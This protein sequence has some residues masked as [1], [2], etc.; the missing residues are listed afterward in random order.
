MSDEGKTKSVLQAAEKARAL[1]LARLRTSLDA[2]LEKNFVILAVDALIAEAAEGDPQAELWEKLHAAAA[3]DAVEDAV[4][5]AYLRSIDGPR[6]R[7][8]EPSAQA[9]VLMHA[10]DFFYGIRGDAATADRL[11]ERVLDLA[12]AR[13][14][15]FT[16]LEQRFEKLGDGLRLLELYGKVAGSSLRRAEVLATQVLHRLLLLKEPLA[17]DAC[18]NV[19]T[20]VPANAKLLDALEAHCRATKRVPLACE[21]I[22]RAIAE[23]AGATPEL[24]AQRRSTLVEL[25]DV[26]SPTKVIDSVEWLLDRDPRDAAALKLGERL[27]SRPEVA[28]R[29]AAALAKARR[30]RGG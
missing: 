12:P 14:D 19:L 24:T 18:R 6:M 26:T 25:Y 20:L 23:D 5:D 30:A 8:L 13:A 11:L 7:R 29:A 1:R 9:D 15:A 10:A 4:A 17:D 16:R 2:R 22:E 27:L 3:R 28:S 21:L